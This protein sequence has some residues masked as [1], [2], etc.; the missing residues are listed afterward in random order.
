MGDII[1]GTSSLSGLYRGNTEI[2]AVYRGSQEIWTAEPPPAFEYP[3]ANIVYKHFA[4]ERPTDVSSS[5]V[6]LGQNWNAY[7]SYNAGYE[8]FITM[9]SDD[10]V[11]TQGSQQ[12]LEVDYSFKMKATRSGS[13]FYVDFPYAYLYKYENVRTG[14][15]GWPT[16]P[17]SKPFNDYGGLVQWTTGAGLRRKDESGN[18]VVV[19]ANVNS[20]WNT[21]RTVSGKTFITIPTYDTYDL[22]MGYM[23]RVK[24]LGAVSGMDV[25][26]L[27]MTVKAV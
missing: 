21:Y 27:S 20:S 9:L 18:W 4:H 5:S 16:V 12:I 22:Q 24:Y 15:P 13:N 8:M 17:K 26:L 23:A 1:R 14:F 11:V 2:Q 3:G 10:R 7:T 25:Q 6:D 19:D